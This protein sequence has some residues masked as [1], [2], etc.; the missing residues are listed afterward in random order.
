MAEQGDGFDWSTF[1]ANL[2]QVADP[3][4]WADWLRGL[5]EG[6]L[7][8]FFDTEP[9]QHKEIGRKEPTIQSPGS[10]V[11]TD[12]SPSLQ[13]SVKRITGVTGSYLGK[14]RVAC[15]PHHTVAKKRH[16]ESGVS[17]YGSKL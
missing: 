16:M 9:I 17:M 7:R 5:Y 4:P 11:A 12:K 15:L 10:K 6:T 1:T 3:L 14:R 2:L 8:Q 13:P